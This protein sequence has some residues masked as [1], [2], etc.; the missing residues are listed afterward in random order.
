V[1]GIAE[2]FGR[3]GG[4]PVTVFSGSI[5]QVGERGRGCTVGIDEAERYHN[6]K[7]PG[8]QQI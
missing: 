6:P 4:R 2:L 3:H 7:D 5:P 8:M 1:K